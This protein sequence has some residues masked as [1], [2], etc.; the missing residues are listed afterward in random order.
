MEHTLTDTGRT[1]SNYTLSQIRLKIGFKMQSAGLFWEI[2]FL[3]N[4]LII[5]LFSIK[6]IIGFEI[7]MKTT[8]GTNTELDKQY[9]Y[10]D[11]AN[12]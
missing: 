6:L 2:E 12:T 4:I 9:T 8:W 5:G 10:S 3:I 7:S 11:K 1:F